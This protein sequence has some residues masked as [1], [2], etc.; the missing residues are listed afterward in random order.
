[1]ALVKL[2][3]ERTLP[4]K[5][6]HL[7]LLT[8]RWFHIS[9]LLQ[10]VKV[11]V[12]CLEVVLLALDT[13][14]Q[15][16]NL[17]LNLLALLPRQAR[18]V[19]LRSQMRIVPLFQTALGVT[20][21]SIGGRTNSLLNL[22]L[23]RKGFALRNR[24]GLI[25]QRLLRISQLLLI[26]RKRCLPLPLPLR[27]F[28][29]VKEA[30]ITLLDRLEQE[31][32][33]KVHSALHTRRGTLEE[34]THL[35]HADRFTLGKLDHVTLCVLSTPTCTTCHLDLFIRAQDSHPLH[36][37]IVL[38]QACEDDRLCGHIQTDCKGLRADK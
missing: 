34:T 19:P 13:R 17:P 28:N 36:I 21:R 4:R 1:M 24:E 7:F 27:L 11:E 2:C 5:M 32:V 10:K 8:H 12:N 3:G 35:S 31:I 6:R 14:L 9:S 37:I 25:V 15:C 16:L 20:T 33:V 30:E 22:L 18:I 26:T 29:H 23:L 38:L